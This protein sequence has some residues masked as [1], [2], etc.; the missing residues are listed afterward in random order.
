[1]LRCVQTCWKGIELVFFFSFSS[2]ENI[3]LSLLS[4]ESWKNRDQDSSILE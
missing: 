4:V 1:M 3:D 2:F